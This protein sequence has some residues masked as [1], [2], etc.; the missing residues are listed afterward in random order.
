MIY[1]SIDVDARE[2]ATKAGMGVIPAN[3]YFRA[4]GLLEH[5]QHVLLIYWIHRLH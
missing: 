4:L 2:P 5:V 3:D 1:L